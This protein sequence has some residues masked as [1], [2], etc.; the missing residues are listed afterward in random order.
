LAGARAESVFDRLSVNTPAIRAE[1]GQ[2]S[3]RP[4]RLN[5]PNAI[6]RAA[7]LLTGAPEG[8]KREL[9]IVSDFQRSNW[10]EVDFTT[11]PEG[12]AIQL[13]S[14]APA[15]LPENLAVQ[16]ISTPF[17]IEQGRDA[18]IEIEVGNYSAR[19]RPVTLEVTIG[20]A[21]SR[22]D[23]TCAAFGKT[24]IAVEMPPRIA[25]WQ[26]G[27]A[28]IVNAN[29]A[30]SADDVRPF[31]VEVRPPPSFALITRQPPGQTVSSSYYLERALAPIAP[32]A[33]RSESRI[34]RIDPSQADNDA[35]SAVD[36]IVL[37]HPGKLSAQTIR[38]LAAML[39][40]GVGLLYV[41]AEVQD[42]VN[43][44]LLT[45]AAGGD[46]RLPVEF[47]PPARGARRA[48]LFLIEVKKEQPPF[49]IFGDD[50]A[51]S[52]EGLRFGGGLSSRTRDDGLADDILANLSDRSAGLVATSCGD[53]TLVVL[54]TDLSASNLP[55][56]PAFV[57][58]LGELTERLCGRKR[59]ADAW[60]CGEP[61][62][63]N[64]PRSAIPISGLELHGPDGDR[65]QLK[66][67]AG[68][69]IWNHPG[70]RKAGV[71]SAKRQGN[72]VFATAA[73]VP[74]EE[75][76]PRPF[77]MSTIPEK[78][79]AGHAIGYHSATGSERDDDK[80]WAW[81]MVGCL[82]CILFELTALKWFKT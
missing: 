24:T 38:Q 81:L 80:S 64:L 42:A 82:A 69:A 36:V 76:D 52:I 40:R 63:V 74:P 22:A 71:Y 8:V 27:S 79:K 37:D 31:V 48:N 6:R 4:E 35:L 18:R 49:A 13:E 12:T 68:G 55:S 29:D 26:A 78:A 54:N 66:E 77:D 7:D 43:L 15:E 5:V 59:A 19:S 56:S 75:G 61:I 53:G 14:V 33:G 70:P 57:P 60:P 21:V 41:T 17:R 62:V 28:R 51:N 39:K 20:D 25:G 30:L 3:V 65:G 32:R 1:L 34:T 72:I 10:V 46:L 16:R 47:S 67:D 44:Q 23:G 50:L 11:L 58:L 2:A 73:A 45:D 9:V